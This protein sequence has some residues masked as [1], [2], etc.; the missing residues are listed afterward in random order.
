MAVIRKVL[1]PLGKKIQ[2]E[3]YDFLMIN[4]N[5]TVNDRSSTYDIG[6]ELLANAV[7]YG[8]S[9]VWSSSEMSLAFNSIAAIPPIAIPPAVT[10]GALTGTII[11]QELM[12]N[13]TE[14]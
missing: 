7:S 9:K 11:Y 14:T 1:S 6:A 8:I 12:K 3:I 5:A 2:G 10:P 4:I 13:F